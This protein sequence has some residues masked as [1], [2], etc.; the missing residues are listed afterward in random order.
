M[1]L[2]HVIAVLVALSGS[3]AL[4]Y[5]QVTHALITQ[6]AYYRSLLPSVSTQ[7]SGLDA[8]GLNGLSPLGSEFRYFELGAN[9][10]GGAAIRY[11]QEYEKNRVRSLS[12]SLENS[13]LTWL[14]FGAIRED[15]NPNEDPP[16]PQDVEPDVKRPIHHFYDPY[17]DRPLI[18]VVSMKN[19]DWAIGSV[20]S[21]VDPNLPNRGRVNRFTVLDAREAMF[22][23]LTLKGLSDSGAYE[24][25]AATIGDTSKESWRQAYWATT[26]RAL[27]NVLHLNQD[28]AQPQHTRN[29]KHSGIYCVYSLCPAGHTSVYEKYI[30]A[31]AR[32]RDTFVSGRQL[33][34]IAVKEL[35]F[36]S[37]QVPSYSKYTD[38]W[39]TSRGEGQPAGK[40]LA[41]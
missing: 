1:R 17:F 36:N 35:S 4:A 16:T 3:S 19:P 14:M 8:L 13:P 26:F 28:M 20:A 2:A 33:Q 6:E 38:Y 7:S 15:D 29:E 32:K 31:R 11:A 34:R 24:D 37:Y 12:S 41:D 25:I 30:D 27:G 18:P 39:S 10:I 9:L 23:A 22:R 5:E 40:G 21:F